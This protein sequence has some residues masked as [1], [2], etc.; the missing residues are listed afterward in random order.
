MSGAGSLDLT[1]RQCKRTDN[2]SAAAMR[3]DMHHA[4]THTV[5]D[6]RQLRGGVRDRLPPVIGEGHHFGV[7]A[8][9]GDERSVNALDKRAGR[10]RCAS[11]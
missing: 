1:F 2:Q 10:E 5:D 6:G 8:Q 4:V 7:A 9:A 11:A 3:D